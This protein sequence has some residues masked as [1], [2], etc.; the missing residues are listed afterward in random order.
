MRFVDLKHQIINIDYINRVH[1]IRDGGRNVLVVS[2]NGGGNCTVDVEEDQLKLLEVLN[3]SILPS[4]PI[5]NLRAI[6]V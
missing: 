1:F 4:P 5:N 3:E 6:K 2:F